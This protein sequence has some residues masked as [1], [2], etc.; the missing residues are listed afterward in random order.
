MLASTLQLLPILEQ[1]FC[2]DALAQIAR[3]CREHCRQ[4][5]TQAVTRE[6]T[7]P[8]VVSVLC[9]RIGSLLAQNPDAEYHQSVEQIIAAPLGTV[10]HA[11]DAGVALR[12]DPSVDELLLAY[13]SLKTPQGVSLQ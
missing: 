8:Y 7:A 2:F 3:A 13:F 9:D 6:L 10:L 11:I 12:G 1:G 5:A 4:V